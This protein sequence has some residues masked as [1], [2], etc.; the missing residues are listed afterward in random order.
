[1]R[2]LNA[3]RHELYPYACLSVFVRS[4]RT[5]RVAAITLTTG[6]AAASKASQPAVVA[7]QRSSSSSRQYESLYRCAVDELQRLAAENL[8]LSTLLA[9]PVPAAASPPP[10][11]H[12]SASST[13]FKP[14]LHLPAKPATLAQHR[15]CTASSVPSPADCRLPAAVLLSGEGGGSS[16]AYD[17]AAAAALVASMSV[18][19]RRGTSPQHDP[20]ALSEPSALLLPA[21]WPDT[22]LLDK[23][24]AGRRAFI[25]RPQ[26]HEAADT[27]KHVGSGEWSG[28]GSS[29]RMARVGGGFAPASAAV[30]PPGGG[31]WLPQDAL[32][33]VQ[34]FRQVH[35][36]ATQ[37]VGWSHWQALL[38]VLDEAYSAQAA[39]VLAAARAK[40]KARV[41]ELKRAADHRQ[42]Y[43]AIL[44]R[45]KLAGLQRQASRNARRLQELQKHVASQDA[46]A[47]DALREVA[48]KG[49]QAYRQLEQAIVDSAIIPQHHSAA[50]AH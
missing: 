4:S 42:P 24:A 18:N 48:K 2:Q 30:W 28:G 44:A 37:S 9:A 3:C 34:A 39:A 38:L 23:G 49:Y 8:R 11:L 17:A 19:S 47:D 15:P 46:A 32:R 27:F 12:C 41:K 36:E 10:S 43:P 25:P 45:E 14:P 6:A 16:S 21:G 1:M 31:A 35:G 13:P 29:Y 50:G 20:G 22:L 33:A 5:T 40:H 7:A 26:G